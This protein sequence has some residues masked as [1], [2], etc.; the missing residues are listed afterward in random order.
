MCTASWLHQDSGFQLLFNRDEKRSRLRAGAPCVE[1]RDSVLTIAPVD[2]DHGGT[3]I[4]VNARGLA[5]CLLNGAY[6]A[7][8]ARSRGL[9]LSGLAGARTAGEAL[10]K[11][12]AANLYSYSAF[13]IVVLQPGR[14]AAVAEWDGVA[15]KL[16]LDGDAQVPMAS[17]SVDPAGVR[18]KR[19]EEFARIM[20]LRP[21][22]PARLLRFHGSHGGGADAYSPCMHRADAETV[23]FSWVKVS[24]REVTFFYTPSAP[25]RRIPGQTIVIPRVT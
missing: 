18:V 4:S 24:P 16:L 7:E 20:G 21:A 12:A 11:L 13:K 10:E 23:S 6:R 1:M 9:L 25:C 5:L 14:S 2:G 15:A 19:R 8:S 22:S 3:W 17:S